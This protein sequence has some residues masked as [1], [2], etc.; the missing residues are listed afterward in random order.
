M[1]SVS[2]EPEMVLEPLTQAAKDLELLEVSQYG[3][4]SIQFNDIYTLVKRLQ[5]WFQ[6][7]CNSSLCINMLKEVHWITL[8]EVIYIN[9]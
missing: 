1:F 6:E 9:S 2:E 4:F 8:W 3:Q 5:F 7:I